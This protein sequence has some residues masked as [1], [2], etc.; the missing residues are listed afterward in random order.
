MIS[1]L[2]SCLLLSIPLPPVPGGPTPSA[3]ATTEFSDDFDLTELSLE[4]L[5]D[6]EVTIATRT[7]TPMSSV[8]AAVYVL[9]GDEIRRAGHSSVQEALRMV[10]GMH[11]SRWTTGDWDVT[12]RGFGTGVA[13]TNSAYL[14]QMLVMIDGVV[15]Y[16]PLFAGMFWSLQDVIMEDIDRIEIVRGPGGILWGSN[17]VHG[18]VNIIT[19]NAGETEGLQLAARS[20]TS[21]RHG[22]WRYGGK[23]GEDS[24]YRVWVKGAKY[25]TLDNPFGGFDYDYS[26]A[27]A[28]GRMDWKGGGN[29]FSFWVRAYKGKFNELGYDLTTF[30]PIQVQDKRD[31][32]QVYASMT[33]DESGGRWQVWYTK[34][35]Q[36]LPT[37]GDINI[38]VYDIEYQHPIQLWENNQVNVGAGYR[39]TM[40]RLYGDDPFWYDFEPSKVNQDVFRVF[41]VDTIALDSIQSTVTIGL[42][43]EYNEFTDFEVQPTLRYTWAPEDGFMVWGAVSRAV[44]TP[45]LEERTLTDNSFYAGNSQFRSET[46]WAYELGTRWMPAD[47]ISTDLA[48]FFNDYDDLNY[49]DFSDPTVPAYRLTNGAEGMS[50]GAE[51][52][53]DLQLNEDWKVRTAYTFEKGD[54]TAD[55]GTQLETG[56]YSPTHSYNIRSYFNLTDEWEF[57]T[58]IYSVSGLAAGL[59]RANYTRFDARIGWNPGDDYKVYIG[60]QDAFTA[61]RSEFDQYDNIPRAYYMG[62]TFSH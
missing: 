14:N 51:L 38:D 37:L 53:V 16:S 31:G 52:A 11:V 10:P 46:L 27:S 57:D 7:A 20:G 23:F 56:N 32:A 58:G 13:F 41:G 17:A 3:P 25:D 36:D 6:M 60:V 39:R 48:L 61:S 15:V 49:A 2:I 18:V 12:S 19:K 34:D 21:D 35:E 55:D 42:A 44:R 30:A 54:F 33:D 9:T 62:M 22:S 24:S 47:W 26:L 45:S 40:S 4:A 50:Y 28:G 43:A 8:P 5:M 1:P 59:E 29:T